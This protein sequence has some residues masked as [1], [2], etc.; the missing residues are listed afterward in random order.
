MEK[1]DTNRNDL[2]TQEELSPIFQREIFK[3]HGTTKEDM[4]RHGV[5]LSERYERF[6]LSFKLYD[7]SNDENLDKLEL[8]RFV[9]PNHEDVIN[10]KAEMFSQE[11]LTARDQD[12]EE[13]GDGTALDFTKESMQDPRRY[14]SLADGKFYEHLRKPVGADLHMEL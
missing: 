3:H 6:S 5:E 4:Q 2:L 10:L 9:L 1:Y 11:L 8:M 14:S 7:S 13:H 12:P